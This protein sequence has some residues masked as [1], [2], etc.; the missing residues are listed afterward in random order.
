MLVSSFFLPLY[1]TPESRSSLR[2]QWTSKIDDYFHLCGPS[3]KASSLNNPN[4]P[5]AYTGSIVSQQE[6]PLYSKTATNLLMILK[7]ISYMTIIIPLTMLLAKYLLRYPYHLTLLLSERASSAPITQTEWLSSTD[8]IYIQSQLSTILPVALEK[9][10]HPSISYYHISADKNSVF[11]I[12]DFPNLIFKTSNNASCINIRFEKM[13]LLEKLVK[14]NNYN[15]LLIPRSHILTISLPNKKFHP[16]IIEQK[17]YNL[18]KHKKNKLGWPTM[19]GSYGWVEHDKNLRPAIIQA[20]QVIQKTGLSDIFYRNLPA[21]IDKNTWKICLLDTDVFKSSPDM[22]SYNLSQL[23]KCCWS[24]ESIDAVIAASDLQKI[25]E[26]YREHFSEY[27]DN[28]KKDRLHDLVKLQAD[29]EPYAQMQLNLGNI[30]NP[31][32]P[33]KVDIKQLGLDLTQTT[34]NP[35]NERV[36]IIS[37]L[38]QI[39]ATLN[40]SLE[41]N[42]HKLLHTYHNHRKIIF[43]THIYDHV[44]RAYTPRVNTLWYLSLKNAPPLINLLGLNQDEKN[45]F[46]GWLFLAEQQ[47]SNSSYGYIKALEYQKKTWLYQIITALQEKGFIFSSDYSVDGKPNLLLC[48]NLSLCL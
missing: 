35:S 37:Y 7:I 41:D 29:K 10:A 17:I 44:K 14:T 39:I 36:S 38:N 18:D 6:A 21:I 5:W 25:P 13:Q 16:C 3:L 4:D 40:Q 47:N 23:I 42:H 9:K 27:L 2:E 1:F 45:D 33:I 12:A 22:V 20:A 15:K 28:T 46:Q 31:H 48:S 26:E 8:L 11:E 19:P 43:D 34:L 30:N 24:K 32:K